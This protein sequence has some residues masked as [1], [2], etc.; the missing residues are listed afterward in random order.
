MWDKLNPYRV[1]ITFLF[2]QS[3]FKIVINIVSWRILKLED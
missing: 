2:V 3:H 1:F